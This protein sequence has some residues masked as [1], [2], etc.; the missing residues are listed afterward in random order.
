M[1][2]MFQ[3]AG[4]SA[5]TF[6]LNLSNWNT[7]NVTDMQDMFNDTGYRATTW[8]ITIPKNNNHGLNNT[9]T[10]FYGGNSSTYA[11]RSGSKLFTVAN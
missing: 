3:S 11:E 2:G 6:N 1:K 7:S 8:N 9:T 4:K 10:R 5:T